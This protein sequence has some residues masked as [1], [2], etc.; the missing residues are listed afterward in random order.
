VD[1]KVAETWFLLDWLS[2]ITQL[3]AVAIPVA[4]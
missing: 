4:A 3:Q 1:R 2:V